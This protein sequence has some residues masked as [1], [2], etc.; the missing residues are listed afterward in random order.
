MHAIKR[1]GAP[2]LSLIFLPTRKPVTGQVCDTASDTTGEISG[3]NPR[4]IVYSAS[5][6]S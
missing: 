3:S 6:F 1:S 2:V 5:L 4:Y